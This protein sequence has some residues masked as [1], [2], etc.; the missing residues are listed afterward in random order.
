VFRD[1]AWQPVGEGSDG[2]ARPPARD[3]LLPTGITLA[4]A[5]LV[6]TAIGLG[7]LASS[8]TSTRVCGL[9]G[10]IGFSDPEAQNSAVAMIAAGVGAGLFSG[11][12]AYFGASGPASPRRSNPRTVTG[13]VFTTLGVANA[14]AGVANAIAPYRLRGTRPGEVDPGFGFSG[15]IHTSGQSVVFTLVSATCLGIGLPLWV[16]GAWAPRSRRSGAASSLD[17]LPAPGGA[18]IRWTR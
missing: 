16:T 11:A 15:S 14:I 8:G 17:L 7:W 12:V 2:P 9:S 13:V 1:G 18:A 10:C 3:P 4:A 5:G 6:T